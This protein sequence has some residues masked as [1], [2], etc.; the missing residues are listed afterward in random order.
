LE[1]ILR[2]GKNHQVRKM[3]AAMGFPTLRLVRYKISEWELGK[4]QPGEYKTIEIGPV[5][6]LKFR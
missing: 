3:T 6:S 1:I 5:F 2:E 4:L